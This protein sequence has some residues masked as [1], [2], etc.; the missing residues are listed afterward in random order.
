[1]LLFG[2]IGITVGL[3]KVCQE[4]VT[5]SKLGHSEICPQPESG[6]A[7][8][9]K[10]VLLDSL[11]DKIKSI[12]YRF[13]LLGSLLPDIIDKPIW[14]FTGSNFN[15]NGHGY[16]H[17][18]LFNFLLLIGGIILATRQ[19]KT[20]LITISL[21]SFIHLVFDQ[22]WLNTTTLWW[23]LSGSIQ[24][25]A[26]TRWLSSLWHGLISNPYLY[27]SETMGFIL[28]LY[29]AL[30]LIASGRVIQFLKTGHID[31][32]KSPTGNKAT[33]TKTR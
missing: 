25:G 3:V 18:F 7:Q 11:Q 22:M 33:E 2:H 27:I 4:L 23:P 31:W 28:T 24:R 15:W 29:I 10:H 14:I 20:W 9:T 16:A 26:T 8:S 13:V 32:S 5:G 19:N 6:T 21:C 1:M 12:D 17:T 30:R